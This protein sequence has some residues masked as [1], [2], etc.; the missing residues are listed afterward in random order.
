[1]ADSPKNAVPSE[2][3][4]THVL[5]FLNDF[6]ATSNAFVHFKQENQTLERLSASG[7][8]REQQIHEEDCT[9]VVTSLGCQ[10]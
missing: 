1:M 5:L 2:I 9:E 8:S 3:C 4:E 6:T 10:G 7:N